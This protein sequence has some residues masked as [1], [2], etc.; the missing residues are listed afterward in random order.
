MK[1]ASSNCRCV[2]YITTGSYATSRDMWIN[3][4]SFATKDNYFHRHFPSNAFFNFEFVTDFLY[5]PT[6]LIDIR[7]TGLTLYDDYSLIFERHGKVLPVT[8]I[9]LFYLFIL[10]IFLSG[11]NKRLF[12]ITSKEKVLS[13]VY[14]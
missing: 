8:L 3:T 12:C 6:F 9:L 11:A 4:S 7:Y 13:T 14:I 5:F 1:S 10:Y 2:R